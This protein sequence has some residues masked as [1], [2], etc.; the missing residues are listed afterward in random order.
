[1]DVGPLVES[2]FQCLVG[3]VFLEVPLDSLSMMSWSLGLTCMH[4]M[5]SL[6]DADHWYWDKSSRRKLSLALLASG[7]V[8]LAGLACAL[9]G[10]RGKVFVYVFFA[11]FV[12][13]SLGWELVLWALDDDMPSQ[14]QPQQQQQQSS[15][16]VWLFFLRHFISGS[17]ESAALVAF[18]APPSLVDPSVDSSHI[19]TQALWLAAWSVSRQMVHRNDRQKKNQFRVALVLLYTVIGSIVVATQR[20]VWSVLNPRRSM[21]LLIMSLDPLLCFFFRASSS[22]IVVSYLASCVVL[23]ESPYF[24]SRIWPQRDALTLCAFLLLLVS[25][26]SLRRKLHLS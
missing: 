21:I 11:L 7:V 19:R 6:L 12:Y 14:Q 15:S 10:D 4:W 26:W 2:L 23:L 16:H 5:V 25:S 24:M 20:E 8:G 22:S 3:S 13:D 18:V 9:A 17:V 1:M